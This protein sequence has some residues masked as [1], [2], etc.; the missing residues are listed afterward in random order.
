MT[1]LGAYYFPGYHADP[2][3]GE[4]HGHGWTEWDVLS[5]AR[6]RFEGHLQPK[7]P[8][9][10][11][12]DESDPH[13][14]AKQAQAAASAG[15]D[16]FIFDWYWYNNGPFLNGALDRGFLGV[17]DLPLDFAIM[18]A[19]HDWQ[20]IHPVGAASKPSVLRRGAVSNY[21]FDCMTEE[22]ITK[23]FLHPNYL[24]IDGAP[25]FSIYEAQTLVDG[26]GSATETAYALDRLRERARNFGIDDVHINLIV[27]DRAVLP[28]EQRE[29]NGYE[30]LFGAASTTSYVWIHH[31]DPS[32]F[33]FPRS[34]YTEVA[35]EN[36]ALWDRTMDQQ[37]IPYF[38]NVTVAWDSSPRTVQSDVYLDRGYPW[39]SVIESTPDEFRTALAEAVRTVGQQPPSSQIVTINAWNEWTEGS[40]LLPDSH[41]G[42]AHLD[43]IRDAVAEGSTVQLSE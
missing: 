5:R 29:P 23:Y 11:S 20:D 2:A 39:M 14:G 26:L 6:P 7:A 30:M 10:G 12:F 38:P 22:L 35:K 8:L 37:T 13:W 16:F 33:G 42:S 36:R 27:A 3:T 17:P 34:V 40:Y 31:S 19:N 41:N 28:G 18:W 32:A 15:L 43:A 24:R 4:W 1:K 9:W 25:Y 21:E